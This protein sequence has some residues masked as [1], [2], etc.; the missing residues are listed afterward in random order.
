MCNRSLKQTAIS[1]AEL[2]GTSGSRRTLQGTSLQ[3][4]GLQMD[5]DSGTSRSTAKDQEDS[6]TLK[7][8]AWQYNNG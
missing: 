4:F 6:S 1:V 8:D 2:Q 7:F 3:R 5:S